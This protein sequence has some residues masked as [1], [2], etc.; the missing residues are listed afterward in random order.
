[1]FAAGC[2]V[3]SACN[4]KDEVD[5]E[6]QIPTVV[7]Q[8]VYNLSPDFYTLSGVEADSSYVVGD[9]LTLTLSPASTLSDGFY[10]Y[11]IQHIFVHVGDEVYQPEHSGTEAV[12]SLSVD[13]IVPD[14]D[15]DVVYCYSVQQ[16]LSDTGYTMSLEPTDAAKLYGVK[17]DQKYKYFDCYLHTVDAYTIENIE[18]KMGD[19]DWQNVNDS[20]GCSFY[21]SESVENVYCVSIRPGYEEVTGDVTIRI[22][23]TPHARYQITYENATAEYLDLE[24]SILPSEQIDGEYVTATLY[25]NDKYYIKTASSSVE[26]APVEILYGCYASFTMPASDITVT[27]NF[28][29]KIPVN[30]TAS[31]NVAEAQFYDN[32]DVYYGVPTSVGV[33]GEYVYL[34]A[35]AADGYKPA[36][37]ALSSGETFDFVH[38]AYDQYY[39]QI[40]IPEDATSVNASIQTTKAYRVSTAI[41]GIYLTSGSLFAEG[42]NVSFSIEVPSGQKIESVTISDASGNALDVN[43]VDDNPY[44]SFTMPACDVT[45]S[46]E[47]AEIGDE[48]VSVIAYF[49][50]DV[51]EVRSSTNYDWDFANGFSVN[52][53]STFYLKVYNYD[54]EMF[55]VGVQIGE[56]VTIY[57][58][59]E[60]PD[61][62]EVYFGK[63]LVADGNV[64]IKVST[65]KSAISF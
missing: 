46:A 65:D 35:T 62:G 6:P 7:A 54:N 52:K 2:L 26:S 64:V 63:A 55:Y 51:F 4:S 13:V 49:D 38:Y 41:S 5:P 11:H 44:Y 33:P 8:N 58:A 12:S 48:Q 53:G 39:A 20:W 23:G 21:R 22:S 17:A 16:Q 47:F 29:E 10:N 14:T 19:G 27:L 1:M 59:E 56:T 25:V 50:E 61:M 15:F 24:K 40:L 30:Y 60:D 34:F 3:F 32:N 45:V 42:E 18:Y 57:D 43:L 37:A 28:M 36:K 31:E 9:T